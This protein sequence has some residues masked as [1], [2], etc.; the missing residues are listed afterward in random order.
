M[1]RERLAASR[2][3]GLVAGEDLHLRSLPASVQAGLGDRQ[4]LGVLEPLAAAEPELVR[5]QVDA[6]L[7]EAQ[8]RIVRE[9]RAVPKNVIASENAPAPGPRIGRR[10]LRDRHHHDPRLPEA[11]GERPPVAGQERDHEPT[12]V[13]IEHHLRVEHDGAPGQARSQ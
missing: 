2:V 8:A 4:D 5:G 11:R 9:L 13:G 7:V 3:P 6:L 12:T 10:G 1:D